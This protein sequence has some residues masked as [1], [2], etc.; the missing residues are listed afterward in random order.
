MTILEV[1][2]TALLS[3]IVI[4]SVLGFYVSLHDSWITQQNVSEMQ[5]SLRVSVDEL[6]S[7]LRNAGAGLPIGLAGIVGADANPDTIM[8]RFSATPSS[9]LVGDPTSNRQAVP[10]HVER[11]SDLSD[12]EVGERVYIY[13]PPS[14]PGEFFTITN[15]SDNAG[16]GWKEVHHQDED[17]IT[18]P[19]PGDII[20]KMVEARY[21]IDQ[22]ADSLHPRFIR[23]VS[24][25]GNVYAEEIS[26]LQ[27]RYTLKD[28]S[29]VDQTAPGDT[30]FAVD[31]SLAAMTVK[32]NLTIAGDEG[33]LNRAAQTNVVLRNHPA[34]N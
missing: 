32:R 8:V 3:T 21:W 11:F 10:I 14:G 30:V 31:L 15:L 2:I 16:T 33:R 26:D 6:V 7:K 1:L 22:S 9:L 34:A 13:R 27:F 29:V 23:E 28:G 24:G 17:L 25:Q 18:D 4:G 5:Q 19:E 12:F 20:F